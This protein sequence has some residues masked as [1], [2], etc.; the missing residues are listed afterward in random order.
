MAADPNN[1]ERPARGPIGV[2]S[3]P[4]DNPTGFERAPLEPGSHASRAQDRRYFDY[5]NTNS[6]WPPRGQSSETLSRMET[7][8]QSSKSGG[9]KRR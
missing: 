9:K 8:Y 2:I 6:S 7:N 1:P 3:H 5:Q 4:P